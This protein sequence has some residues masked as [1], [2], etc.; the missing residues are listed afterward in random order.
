MCWFKSILPHKSG[1]VLP[2]KGM[3][4]DQ[5]KQ[6]RIAQLTRD[7]REVF[8]WFRQG[9]TARWTAETMLLDKK[10]A[11]G[12]FDSVYH[13]LCVKDEVEVSRVYREVKLT[14]KDLPQD[15]SIS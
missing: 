1:T 9:Y 11:R 15:E 2:P 10:T 14:E 5:E 7:E 6:W 3:D 4:A 12:L 13:K 8:E